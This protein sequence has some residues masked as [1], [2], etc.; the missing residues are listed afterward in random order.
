MNAIKRK[1]NIGD[2]ISDI[3]IIGYETVKGTYSMKC[4]CGNPLKGGAAY[5]DTK[6]T[7]FNEIGYAGC[8]KCTEAYFSK[9]KADVLR[10]SIIHNRYKFRAKKIKKEFTLTNEQ[11][12]ILFKSDCF[13]C[14]E[15][16]KNGTYKNTE[17]RNFLFQGID[18]VDNTKG[19]TPE[20][21]VPCCRVCN[22]AKWTQTHEEYI[23]RCTKIYMRFKG[24]TTIL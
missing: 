5:I 11:S 12:L 19:Y 23:E 16:P 13:Y 2:T 22:Y 24:S 15:E 14:G 10:Y 6:L 9:E 21:T 18:R 8:R 4:K 1:Y 20:N 17:T 7:R 3:S